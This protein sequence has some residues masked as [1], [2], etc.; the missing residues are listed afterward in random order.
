MPDGILKYKINK[1]GQEMRKGHIP[2]ITG[3]VVVMVVVCIFV[4]YPMAK[5]AGV[6]YQGKELFRTEAEYSQFKEVIGEKDISIKDIS[7]LSSEPPIIVQFRVNV[8]GNIQF[9]YGRVEIPL[10]GNIM[11]WEIVTILAIGGLG[12]FAPVYATW[13]WKEPE[14]K[15]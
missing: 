1:G 13:K 12:I 9:G 2:Y 15:K 5:Q 7:V 3:M 14:K 11:G 6:V 10:W 4:T 8:P